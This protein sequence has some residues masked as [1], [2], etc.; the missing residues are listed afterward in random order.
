MFQEQANQRD[1]QAL[2]ERVLTSP[3]LARKGG[4]KEVWAGALGPGQRNRSFI[5]WIFGKKQRFQWI[6][7]KKQ[8]CLGVWAG[9]LGPG[10]R[11]KH[12]IQWI[13]GKKQGFQWIFSKKQR[14][15][16]NKNLDRLNLK[17]PQ[18]KAR[19]MVT[20]PVA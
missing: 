12:S 15:Q 11:N 14:F 19:T 7:G 3:T 1:L 10:Q 4:Q 13:F 8:R 6:F 16:R 18:M 17:Q 5:Q 2:V 9:A 20:V